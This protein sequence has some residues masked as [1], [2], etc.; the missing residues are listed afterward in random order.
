MASSTLN[1]R[2]STRLTNADGRG[3]AQERTTT[4]PVSV[5]ATRRQWAGLMVLAL[6]CLV[7]SMDA[8]LLHLALPQLSAEL[9]PSGG[10][11]LWIVD[12]YVFLGAGSL[13]T[14]GMI[15]DRVGRRR[16]LLVGA[17]TFAATSVLAAFATSA[18]MLIAARGLLGVAGATLM[19]STLAL[20]RTMFRDR[21]QRR[22]AL[23]VWT[24]SFALGG[25]VGPVV[26][27]LVLRSLPWS[28]VFLVAIP[29]MLLLL[30]L[31]PVLLPESR[32]RAAS[33][34]DVV[35]AGTSLISVLAVVFGVKSLAA[36]QVSGMPL[37]AIVIGLGLGA[38]LVRRLRRQS[39][40]ALDPLLLGR[41]WFVAPLAVNSLAFFVLYGTQYLTAQYVQLVLG[42]S[43]L[44]AGLWS[45]PGTLAY[46]LGSAIGPLATRH[47]QPRTV[48]ATGLLVSAAGFGL[49]TQVRVEEGLGSVVA[50]SVVF[51]I[52]LAPV[53][54]L[55]TEMVV[56]AAPTHQAG[57]VS[58]TQET[59][60]ELGG[61][62]GIALLGSLSLA[63]YRT[64]VGDIAGTLPHGAS[65]DV[66]QT[67]A[68]ALAA[69]DELGGLH[70]MAV[71]EA[72]REAF[73]H[74]FVIA[75]GIG[76]ALL[77]VAAGA[78][79]LLQRRSGKHG[80]V[81]PASSLNEDAGSFSM[82]TGAPGEPAGAGEL[83]RDPA[84]DKSKYGES[85]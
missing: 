27:G 45:I 51:A 55:T 62:L 24:A 33:Q 32:D 3:S 75:E 57:A 17:A 19:P 78:F 34:V 74:S 72:A 42:L 60:A 35:S 37:L 59:G 63:F 54:S 28:T 82:V 64:S 61:A 40:P 44:T 23:G 47:V 84:D 39:S 43:P 68:G 76:V 18:A 9:R 2:T 77:L 67:L 58:A 14:M 36:G 71:A 53:Y 79:T 26:G 12:I 20:I 4:D 69:A 50:G 30:A 52:G 5:H 38:L 49:L 6:P 7:V 25:L 41:V 65:G 21:I 22:K 73:T 15:G 29:P 10:Q 85:K 83:Q 11:L 80:A 46:L 66:R 8:N 31:G 48:V 81:S 56:A 16:L 1:R 70:G 13:L